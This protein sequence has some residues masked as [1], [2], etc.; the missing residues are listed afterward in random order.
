MTSHIHR[1]DTKDG[2]TTLYDSQLDVHYR[3]THGAKTESMTVFIHG[4]QLSQRQSPWTVLELGFGSAVNFLQTVET[5][6]EQT[7]QAPGHLTYHAVE[8]APVQGADLA[9]LPGEAGQLARQA[10]DALQDVSQV[11]FNIKL[12]QL[13]VDLTLHRCAWHQFDQPSLKANAIYHDPFGPKTNPQGW[14]VEAFEV[15]AKHLAQEGILATYSA[16]GHVRRAMRDAG[17][18]CATSPG[19]GFK[20]EITFAAHHRA[21]LAHATIIEK[22]TPT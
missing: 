21:A 18:Y 10:V 6:V 20:R 3:S 17:L 22:Y 11:H 16:A 19:P 7:Q 8:Y 13:T 4:T 12:D 5:L 2:S 9:H 1:Y 15:A 14:T